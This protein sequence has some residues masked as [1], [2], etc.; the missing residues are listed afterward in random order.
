M[1]YMKFRFYTYLPYSWYNKDLGDSLKEYNAFMRAKE[2]DYN[3]A[4]IALFCNFLYFGVYLLLCRLFTI[5]VNSMFC[6]IIVPILLCLSILIA[7]PRVFLKNMSNT[8]EKISITIQDEGIEVEEVL[9]YH[10]CSEKNRHRVSI[11]K[12]KYED[13]TSIE[14]KF[15]NN[16]VYGAEGIITFNKAIEIVRDVNGI[17][18][19]TNKNNAAIVFS[20]GIDLK[21]QFDVFKE[22]IERKGEISA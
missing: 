17:N 19:V 4:F 1:F 13:I 22:C 5:P 21:N 18:S 16:E 3:I 7:I 6:I 9:P 12:I 10:T 14:K 15:E 20:I 2:V 11:T 8:H